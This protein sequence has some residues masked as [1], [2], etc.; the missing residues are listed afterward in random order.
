MHAVAPRRQSRSAAARVGGSGKGLPGHANGE[1][2][3]LCGN[4][5]C[6]RDSG[7]EYVNFGCRLACNRCWGSNAVCFKCYAKSG[8]EPHIRGPR[9]SN[10]AERQLQRE[11]G[12]T[13]CG[14]KVAARLEKS[15]AELRAQLAVANS[16]K[17]PPSETEAAPGETEETVAARAKIAVAKRVLRSLQDTPEKAR[18]LQYG[19]SELYDAALLRTKGMLSDAQAESRD[20][21]PLGVQ[22]MAKKKWLADRKKMYEKASARVNDVEARLEALRTELAGAQAAAVAREAEIAT[23]QGELDDVE[24]QIALERSS[25]H[26]A[27][28]VAMSTADGSEE[29]HPGDDEKPSLSSLFPR[30][31][32]LRGQEMAQDR[33]EQWLRDK[34]E[35]Q[36]QRDAAI[37]DATAAEDRVAEVGTWARA[38]LGIE[39][40]SQAKV[41]AVGEMVLCDASGP[42]KRGAMEVCDVSAPADALN[43][44]ARIAVAKQL[45][46]GSAKK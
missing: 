24:R 5:E 8:A 37:R 10:F 15:V 16:T 1:R 29:S 27:P 2:D 41:A 6:M 20:S 22:L 3:W 35:L 30:A 17:A 21:K 42:S 4:N 39:V 9:V 11:A 40:P 14:G 12:D 26:S 25:G 33:E 7:E 43:K 46:G 19:S 28:A 38:K 18:V 23:A 44:S 13:R 36:A 34:E 45:A 31:F 32:L